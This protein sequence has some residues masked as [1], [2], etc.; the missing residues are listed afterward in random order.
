LRNRVVGRARGAAQGSD[1][2][3]SDAAL[4]ELPPGDGAHI[5]PR[6]RLSGGAAE[7]LGSAAHPQS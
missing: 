7:D 3:V 6:D 1:G 5:T 4:L 2:N